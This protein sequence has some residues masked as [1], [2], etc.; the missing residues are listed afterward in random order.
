[1]RLVMRFGVRLTVRRR[2]R[3]GV[4]LGQRL[5]A[6]HATD[7]QHECAHATCVCAFGRD[8]IGH[9]VYLETVGRAIAGGGH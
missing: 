9:E 4:G 1:M 2:V 8:G 5:A 6:A 7:S 3:L